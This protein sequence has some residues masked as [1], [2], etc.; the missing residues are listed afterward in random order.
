MRVNL[1]CGS[2][3]MEGYVNLDRMQ[4]APGVIVHDL[5]VAPWPFESDSV[6]RMCAMDVFEHVAEPLV[7]INEAWRVLAPGGMFHM[8]VPH[9]H[10]E[11]AFTDPTHRRF[12][13]V[14]TWDYWIPGT[15]LHEHHHAAYGPAEFERITTQLDRGGTIHVTLRKA[16]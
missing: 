10:A 14:H 15:V 5:D 11:H 9:Y 2:D 8:R 1:G 4:T 3:L 6:E 12:C 13:T 16:F 7:F